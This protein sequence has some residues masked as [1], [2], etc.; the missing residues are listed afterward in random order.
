ME[1]EHRAPSELIAYA[2]N[3]RKHSPEQILALC[4]SIEKFGFVGAVVVNKNGEI[5]AGHGRVEAA[6]KLKLPTIPTICAAHLSEEDARLLCVADNA[7]AEQSTWDLNILK[8]EMDA[9]RDLKIDFSWLDLPKELASIQLPSIDPNREDDPAPE[10]PDPVVVLGDMFRI[11]NHLILCGDSTD[12][13]AVERVLEGA[14]PNCCVTDPP[15]GVKYD[16]EWRKRIVGPDGLKS[17]V[18]SAGTVLNDDRSGWYD[19]YS[20]FSGEV[21]YVFHSGLYATGVFLDLEEAEFEIRC[22]IIWNKNN[23][24]LSRGHYHWKH[25]AAWY[26]VRKGSTGVWVGDRKQNSVWDV[27]IISSSRAGHNAKTGHSTQKPIAL[28]TRA[29]AN[30]CEPGDHVYEPF[31]GS[32]SAM[33]AS[34]KLGLCCH[35]IELSPAYVQA[36]LLRMTTLTGLPAV[37]VENGKT[38][39]E[40]IGA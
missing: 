9:L 25:E 21:I 1:I 28:Y 19:S 7:L 12:A 26:A 10:V 34:H 38:L 30:H 8:T 23:A 29:Y 32:G 35:A 33:V 2:K 5:I 24:P 4:Q 22:Q 6:I 14:S 27:P 13:L 18:R 16:P 31:S 40:M 17:E 20:L 37:H 11:G 3:A 39:E 36:A 15:Y